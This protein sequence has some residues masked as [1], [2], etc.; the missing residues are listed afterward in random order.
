MIEIVSVDLDD[1]TGTSEAGAVVSATIKASDMDGAIPV[2][3]VEADGERVAVLVVFP[4]ADVDLLV[5][6][7]LGAVVKASLQ[8]VAG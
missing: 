2:G 4:A 3:K 1:G 5:P 8:S 7:S 6:A